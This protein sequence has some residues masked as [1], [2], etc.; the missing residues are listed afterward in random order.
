MTNW[1]SVEE[2]LPEVNEHV[3]LFLDN[4]EGCTGQVVGYLFFTEDEKFKEYN[5]EF[6]VY[7]GGPL[8]DFLIK[9]Y[10]KA[11]RALPEP[12]QS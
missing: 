6:S 12:Y 1:I 10:V 7:A 2:E 9:K 5:N 3:L 8:P 4:D 11:W